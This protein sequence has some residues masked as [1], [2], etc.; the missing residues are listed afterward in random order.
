MG[1]PDQGTFIESAPIKKGG[2][3]FSKMSLKSGYFFGS[4]KGGVG[5]KGVNFV[6]EWT[7]KKLTFNRIN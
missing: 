3:S 7:G 2:L 6:K 4:V 1:I 5:L